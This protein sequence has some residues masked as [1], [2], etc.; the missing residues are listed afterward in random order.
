MP[1]TPPISTAPR[2]VPGIVPRVEARVA[3][4]A[5]GVPPFNPYPAPMSAGNIIFSKM[6]II[7]MPPPQHRSMT[8][9]QLQQFLQGIQA[10]N[11]QLYQLIVRN[12]QVLAQALRGGLSGQPRRPRPQMMLAPEEGAAIERVIRLS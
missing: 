8:P 7:G 1:T 12:P 4:R 11:P 10:S 6:L 9:L 5:V 3:P 2:M